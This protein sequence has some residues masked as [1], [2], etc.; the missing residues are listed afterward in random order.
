MSIF[1]KEESVG[2]YTHEALDLYYSEYKEGRMTLPEYL[3]CSTNILDKEYGRNSLGRQLKQWK[4][5]RQ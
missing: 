3:Q 2:N 1:D 4:G 5:C